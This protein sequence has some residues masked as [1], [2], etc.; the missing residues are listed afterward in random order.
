MPGHRGKWHVCPLCNCHR[1]TVQEYTGRRWRVVG[2]YYFA[3]N[4]PRKYVRAPDY[5]EQNRRML[6]D[7]FGVKI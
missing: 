1:L 6:K 7:I 3:E 5:T 4:A 2:W